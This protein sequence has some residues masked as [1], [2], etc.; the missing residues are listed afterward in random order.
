MTRVHLVARA[1]VGGK[2]QW[3]EQGRRVLPDSGLLAVWRYFQR[4]VALHSD[5]LLPAGTDPE[6]TYIA[7]HG[8]DLSVRMDVQYNHPQHLAMIDDLIRR[9]ATTL[10]KLV[11]FSDERWNPK[12]ADGDSFRYIEIGGVDRR[13]GASASIGEGRGRRSVPRADAGTRWRPIGQPHASR[14]R[15]HCAPGQH[16]R[17]RCSDYGL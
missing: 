3:E 4:A 5:E 1:T 15:C 13:W 2:A 14:S 11:N 17:R 6:T 8:G 12:K 7:R 10:D 9:G 16:L